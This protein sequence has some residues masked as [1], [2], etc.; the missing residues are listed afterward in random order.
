MLRKA[1]GY[2]PRMG[3]RLVHSRLYSKATT[4]KSYF[5]LF[6]QTFPDHGPPNESFMINPRRLRREYRTLQSEHHPDIVIGS[7]ALSKLTD[8]AV[9]DKFS[10][11]LNKAYSTISNPYSRIAHLIELNHPDHLDITQDDISKKLISDF[12]SSSD[13]RSLEYKNMLMMVL[14]AHESLELATQ[15]LDLEA[16]S[17]ENDERIDESEEAIEQLLQKKPLDW[18][19]I[20]MEAVRLKYWINIQKGI[21]DWEPGKP[22]NITH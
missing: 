15:D 21:K 6:P 10:S 8:N 9:D 2:A 11:L 14:E 7:A 1:Y 18:N 20:M 5:D 12:Q 22:V 3:I 19:D 4:I 16:L 17:E 13:E